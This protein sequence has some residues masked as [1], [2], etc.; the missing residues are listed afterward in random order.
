MVFMN[1]VTQEMTVKIVYY[2][3]GLCGK[4]TNL[5]QIYQRTSP[6]TRGEMVSLETEADRTLFFDLLP[7]EVGRIGGY[8]TRLQLYTVPGQVFYNTTR[9]VVLKGVD[10]VVFVADSQKEMLDANLESFKNLRE[11]MDELGIDLDDIPV[12][13]QYNK[14]DLPNVLP[15]EELNRLVNPSNYPNHPAVA[16]R[17]E[18]VFETLKEISKQTLKALRNR[19]TGATQPRP[20]PTPLPR[21][22]QGTREPPRPTVAQAVPSPKAPPKAPPKSDQKIPSQAERPTP[23]RGVPAGEAPPAR[24]SRPVP[25]PETPA[26]SQEDKVEFATSAQRPSAELE[27]RHV[28]V[29]H[30]L[31]VLSELEKL[32]Q[33]PVTKKKQSRI[34]GT[35]SSLEDLLV[36]SANH[37]KEIQKTFDITVKRKD[38]SRARKISISIRLDDESNKALTE[39]RNLD[40][41]LKGAEAIAQLFLDLKVKLEGQ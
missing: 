2:G 23:P 21:P 15:L 25:P 24:P 18:G 30:S 26:D 13:I 40:I 5:Q 1:R 3:P 31:D 7:L 33:T 6:D 9:K 11:N 27:V 37:K 35:S 29:K 28:K 41:S 36:S 34:S 4:T 19:L 22:P 14:R 10:G 8:K 38:L 20:Q 39:V 32:K 17:G 16:V 12:V